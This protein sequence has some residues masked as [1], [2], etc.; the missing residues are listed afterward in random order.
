MIDTLFAGSEEKRLEILNTIV[1]KYPRDKWA[2]LELSKYYRKRDMYSEVKKHAEIVLALDPSWGDAYEELAFA[3]AN[4]GDNE[5]AL[6]YLQKYSANIPGDP[7]ANLT[8]GHFY[9]KMGKIDDAIRKFKDALDIKPD[10]NIENFLAYAYAMKEDYTEMFQWMDN[11]IAKAPSEGMKAG[12]GYIFKGFYH[13]LLGNSQQAIEDLQRSWDIYNELGFGRQW[14]S[15]YIMGY[16]NYERG[17]F[18]LSR[19]QIQSWHDG[20][21]EIYPEEA[22]AVRSYTSFWLYCPLGAIDLNRGNIDS[23]RSQLKKM[24]DLLPKITTPQKWEGYYWL[25]GQILLAEKSYDEAISVLK[26]APRLKMPWLWLTQNVIT[27]NLFN[28]NSFL[29][30]AYKEKGDL[31]KAIEV[32]EQLTDPNPE[33]RDGRLIYP[34]DYY[35]L[36]ILYEMQGQKAKAIRHYEKFL[37]L[38]KDADPGIAEVEDA[39]KRLAGLTKLK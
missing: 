35:E 21:L 28:I 24:E 2:H 25:L 16:V 6:E 39:R 22:V 20:L 1:E 17:E 38:W 29:A 27:Y 23:A 30:Q 8:T 12:K 7:S 9:V 15:E 34:K 37:D 3:Y 33:N 13:Y 18:D 5:K 14:V 11:Y 26:E 31:D 10:F 4:T 19:D 36:A 32:Y